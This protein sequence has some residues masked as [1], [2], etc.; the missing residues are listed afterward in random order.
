MR[1]QL[2]LAQR[3][4]RSICRSGLQVQGLSYRSASSANGSRRMQ[5]HDSTITRWSRGCPCISDKCLYCFWFHSHQDRHQDRHQSRRWCIH[6]ISADYDGYQ[7]VS[8]GSN[9]DSRCRCQRGTRPCACSTHMYRCSNWLS[10][11][12]WSIS[13]LLSGSMPLRRFCSASYNNFTTGYSAADSCADYSCSLA[14]WSLRGSKHTVFSYRLREL[15]LRWRR[16]SCLS[17]WILWM[18]MR[19]SWTLW[20]CWQERSPWDDSYDNVHLVDKDYSNLEGRSKYG[21]MIL[22]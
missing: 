4:R 6:W 11:F 18:S 21:L 2:T 19:R 1:N 5:L 3:F 8:S 12:R 22:C 15:P 9:N 13:N 17:W 10:M 20:L 16:T 14:S 7:R